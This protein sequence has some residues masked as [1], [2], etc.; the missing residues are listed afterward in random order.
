MRFSNDSDTS[1]IAE[2]PICG[3]VYGNEDDESVWICCDGCDA[4]FNIECTSV[5]EREE[6]PDEYFCK[7]CL[8]D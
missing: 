2:C 5:D 8:Q 1:S 6:I 3:A 4:W 7:K